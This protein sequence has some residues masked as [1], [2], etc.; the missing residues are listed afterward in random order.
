MSGEDATDPLA[1]AD[2]E[3]LTEEQA[4]A[5]QS[6]LEILGESCNIQ[7]QIKLEHKGGDDKA[8]LI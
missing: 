3:A 6:H 8:S 5:E 4:A 2:V 7:S 1:G